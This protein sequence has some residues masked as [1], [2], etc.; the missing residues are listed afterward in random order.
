MHNDLIGEFEE[1]ATAHAIWD[2][3][4]IKFS[5]TS[6]TRLRG[7]NFDSYKIRLNHT[8]KQPLRHMSIIIRKLKVASNTLTEE[9]KIQAGL[10][11]LP[12]S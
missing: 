3:L 1:R 6:A 4:K 9:Q 7:L 10:R 5:G 2:A 11:S 12:N 8:M